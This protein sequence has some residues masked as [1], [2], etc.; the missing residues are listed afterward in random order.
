[1][2]RST[3]SEFNFAS[4]LR[5]PERGQPDSGD[6]LHEFFATLSLYRIMI[7]ALTVAGLLLGTAYAVTRNPIY[8]ATAEI[9]LSPGE[10]VLAAAQRDMGG[11]QGGPNNAIVESEI[12]IL[13]SDGLVSLLVQ[14]VGL[15]TARRWV[16]PPEK[17]GL[18]PAPP[19]AELTEAQV[20]A[21]IRRSL[22]VARRE[23]SYVLAISVASHDPGHAAEIANRLVDVYLL[24]KTT[25]R[26]DA[27]RTATDWLT[28]RL[29]ALKDEVT[30]KEAAVEAY[31]AEMDLLSVNGN[32]V[33]ESQLTSIQASLVQAR[34]QYAES[35]ARLQQM[36]RLQTS[37]GSVETISATLSS[38]VMA[39]LRRREAD[40]ASRRAELEQRY[41]PTHP[42]VQKVIKEQEEVRQ[43]IN[44]EVTRI[45]AN[46]ANEVE[47]AGIRVN[48]L[49]RNHDQI[50]L[51]LAGSNRDQVKLRSLQ[52][53][54]EAATNLYQQYLQLAQ[55]TA[56]ESSRKVVDA[57]IVSLA[58]PSEI[59]VSPSPTL[60][61]AFFAA[62]GMFIGVALA[63]L[64]RALNNKL[65]RPE[66]VARKV[67]V[68]ALVSI[69]LVGKTEMSQCAPDE[70]TPAGVVVARPMSRLAESV[71]VLLSQILTEGAD[72][73][74][75]V[76]AVTSALAHEGKT[77]TSL[78][79][80]RVAAMNGQ[81]VLLIDG[82]LRMRSL[83][84]NATVSETADLVSALRKNADWRSAVVA[85]EATSAELLP[86]AP[87]GM[88]LG[89]LFASARMRTI[90]QE[91]RSEYDLI[92]IDCPPIL[93]V[94]DARTLSAMAD[95]TILISQWNATP[96]PAV[97]T[98]LRE[99]DN[100]GGKPI[101]VVLNQ[102]KTSVVKRIS[103]SDSLYLGSAGAKYYTN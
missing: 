63:I 40:V 92:I 64:R 25:H 91:I 61:V 48:E 36:R 14:E 94:A 9:I 17:L 28:T 22:A 101:G 33:A 38:N 44:A 39:E 3:Y 31:R 95:R 100:A 6:G 54:A 80:G 58:K 53:E 45:I 34:S 85:D 70:R 30:R 82:D 74:G 86:A 89:N 56:E 96:A 81:R 76:I 19:R 18:I 62:I 97:R 11:G 52:R 60:W 93:A 42:E 2:N 78:S 5:D 24:S 21:A 71:R 20:I 72:G 57:R 90:L 29:D 46:L 99:I 23:S 75:L 43:Q 47:V 1:M 79:L 51:R 13:K 98:A 26:L 55:E 12:E 32:T 84:R 8:Q 27:S 10:S 66:D 35:Q 73:R 49:Q 16:A 87:A 15:D 59:P 37:G 83:S 41:L 69:P 4:R 68:N 67:G 50:E 65:V 7:L 88:V 103:Y 102:L 77:T